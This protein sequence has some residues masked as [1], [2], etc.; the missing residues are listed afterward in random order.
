M[1]S[2]WSSNDSSFHENPIDFLTLE[3]RGEGSGLVEGFFKLF[4]LTAPITNFDYMNAFFT[5]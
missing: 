1:G 2:H 3:N 4:S 5:C